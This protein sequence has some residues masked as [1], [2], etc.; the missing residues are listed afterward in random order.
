MNERY[1]LNITKSNSGSTTNNTIFNLSSKLNTTSPIINKKQED[2]FYH[3]F[4][5]PEY[6]IE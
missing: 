2:V 3:F 1:N 5:N 4:K 6:K